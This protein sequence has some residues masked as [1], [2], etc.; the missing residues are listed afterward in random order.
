M[1][2]NNYYTYTLSNIDEAHSLIFIF[3]DVTY[4]F[5][6]SSGTNVKLFPSGSMVQLP[7]DYYTLVIIP[8]DYSSKIT[9]MDNN[10]DVTSQIQKKE[11]EVTKDGNT[12]TVINYIYKLSNIQATHDIIVH[13]STDRSLYVKINSN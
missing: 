9:V 11:E 8:D 13:C 3:G 6:N 2:S 4:Y 10:I 12:Y 1:E 7:G 5:V